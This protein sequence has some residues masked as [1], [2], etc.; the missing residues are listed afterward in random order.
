MTDNID[1]VVLAHL[2][3]QVG[4]KAFFEILD[5][6]LLEIEERSN[7]FPDLLKKGDLKGLD[8]GSHALKGASRAFG[9]GDVADLCMQIEAISSSGGDE[10]LS[11][12]LDQL[13]VKCRSTYKHLN[14]TYKQ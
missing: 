8:L 14:D 5:A 10:T 12:L 13:L 1:H 4:A 3:E 11:D 7:L 2:K 9:A 6:Y